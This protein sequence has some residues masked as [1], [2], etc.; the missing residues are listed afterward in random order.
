[1]SS[2]TNRPRK[3]LLIAA[4]SAVLVL[5]LVVVAVRVLGAASE[6]DDPSRDDSPNPSAT[7]SASAAESSSPVRTAPVTPLSEGEAA[8]TTLD[9]LS[10]TASAL[11]DPGNPADLSDVLTDSALDAYLAQAEEFMKTGVHQNGSPTIENARVLGTSEDGTSIQVEACVDSS[12]VQVL[13]D[14]GTDLRASQPKRSLTIFTLTNPDGSWKLASE[15]F[16]EDPTC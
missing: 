5:I 1:M 13:N 9:A 12:A 8:D 7:V 3:R 6:G 15:T 10:R 11:S 14:Q 16:P 2:S 4:I